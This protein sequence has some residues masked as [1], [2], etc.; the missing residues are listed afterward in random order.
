MDR[1]G[2][3][4]VEGVIVLNQGCLLVMEH[5]LLQRAVQVVGFC[6]A[7]SSSRAV[8]HTVLHFPVRA[9]TIPQKMLRQVGHSR[10]GSPEQQLH[11]GSHAQVAVNQASLCL[12]KA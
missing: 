4:D 10:Q 1:V 8:D 2:E 7:V 9:V 3:P 12:L 6:K 5:Q 11:K